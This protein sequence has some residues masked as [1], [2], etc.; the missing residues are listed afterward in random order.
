MEVDISCRPP[1]HKSTTEITPDFENT[2]SKDAEENTSQ[3]MDTSES[4]TAVC[5]GDNPSEEEFCTNSEALSDF[6]VKKPEDNCTTT[7]TVTSNIYCPPS[8]ALPCSPSLDYKLEVVKNGIQ[9]PEC[10][11]YLS[12]PSLSDDTSLES[13]CEGL[14]YCLFGRQPQ[15]N[16]SS[17]NNSHITGQCSIL[18][19]PSI[20]RLHAVL[21]YGKP[22]HAIGNVPQYEKD[23]T[24]WY[25]KDLESTHGTF[26]NK[27]RLP[28]GRFVRIRVGYVLRF[29]GSTRLHILQ[30]PDEDVEQQTTQ[31]WSDLKKSHE[32][33]KMTNLEAGRNNL[34]AQNS[35]AVKLECDWGMSLEDPV[36]EPIPTLLQSGA[37]LSHEKLYRDDPKR[38]LNAFFEREGIDPVPQYEFVE[39]PFGKQH[40][41]IELPLSSGTVTAEAVVSGKRK[42]AVVACA[43]E[44]CQL[45]DRLGEFD[46]DKD[47]SGTSK[48]TRSRAY[49]EDRDYYS[50]DEDTY[51]DRTGAVEKKR[52]NRMRQLGIEDE[53]KT[54]E[55][56]NDDNAENHLKNKKRISQDATMISV[57]SELEKI[58]E[59]IVS[60]E[61]ELQAIDQ[62][63]SS[64][65]ANPSQ[66]DELEAYMN[67]L[68]TSSSKRAQ[69]S[70]LKARLILLRQTELQ[71]F[72]RAGLSKLVGKTRK[73]ING[74][75]NDNNNS[76]YISSSD[77]A[78]AVRAARQK[79][80]VDSGQCGENN[81]ITTTSEQKIKNTRADRNALKRS[82]QSHARTLYVSQKK[83]EIDKPFE[84]EN[85]D[86][87][88]NVIDENSGDMN[89][90]EEQQLPQQTELI[91]TSEL[92][93]MDA[94]SIPQSNLIKSPDS[95]PQSTS[96]ILTT[97]NKKVVDSSSLS[98]INDSNMVVGNNEEEEE[99]EKVIET[100]IC[101]FLDD[102]IIDY[103]LACYFYYYC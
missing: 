68:K 46:Q 38:A 71:L 37:C 34:S 65:E 13:S 41:R 20:S 72:H 53:T 45:L 11:V 2:I 33:R 95:R 50:S 30:G 103:F 29:G 47:R 83:T 76:E 31:S 55:L 101:K 25:L 57:L 69:R 99:G 90:Y 12:S 26:V 88:D 80:R 87:D 51:V 23:T 60:I 3:T 62:V 92:R 59:E 44:A 42:E 8:W 16:Y 58:G 27:R 36:A 48:Y 85:D 52:L 1:S 18:A 19:H 39:A 64:K 79:L 15:L 94:I 40:C 89:N 74:Q 86:D 70:K 9:L 4:T 78:A 75:R 84:V 54:N 10:T 35:S 32:E 67:G 14:S 56:L 6:D 5:G 82:L 28:P 102:L 96:P 63:F 81:Q 97:T 61:E 100:R 24:G 7:T 21:Q 91:N 22:P 73:H 49:W 93:E 98:I 77:A 43:L 17:S 66:L